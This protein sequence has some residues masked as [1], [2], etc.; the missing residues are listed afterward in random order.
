M[1]DEKISQLPAG[2]ALQNSDLVPIARGSGNAKI[3]GSA[4]KAVSITPSI[5]TPTSNTID[6]NFEGI[7]NGLIIDAGSF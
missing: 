5:Y 7:N 2:G 1:A 6:G 4:F 3:L